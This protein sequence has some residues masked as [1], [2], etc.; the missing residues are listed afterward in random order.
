MERLRLLAS[1]EDDFEVYVTER[2]PALLRAARAISGDPHAAEDL[3][4]AALMALMPRWDTLRDRGAADAYARRTMV[5]QHVSWLRKPVH[6][7]E[8]TLARLPDTQVVDR[9][10]A[11][12]EAL[13]TL[14]MALPRARRAA[15]VLRYFEGLS[16][17][18]TAA[19]LGC[20]ASSVKSNTYRGILD[21]RQSVMLDAG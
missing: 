6:R 2:R 11:R 12:D 18:E 1:S 7:H 4:Q 19:L 21:L 20:S 10:D 16:V 9:D 15:I 3:L 17:D 14:V 13:W 8:R 5:N